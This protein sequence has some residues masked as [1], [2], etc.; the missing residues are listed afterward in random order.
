MDFKLLMAFTFNIEK[1]KYFAAFAV[2]K[3]TFI[4]LIREVIIV[5]LVKPGEFH[6]YTI[7]I[8]C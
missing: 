1:K 5:N 8:G 6:G 2:N 3:F 7:T 4:R